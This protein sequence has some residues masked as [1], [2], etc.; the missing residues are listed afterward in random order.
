MTAACRRLNRIVQHLWEAI[1]DQN[2]LKQDVLQLA[3][4]RLGLFHDNAVIYK[5]MKRSNIG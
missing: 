1:R 2:V 3:S 4:I 5:K